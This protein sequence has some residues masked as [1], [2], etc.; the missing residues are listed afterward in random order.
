MGEDFPERGAL[1]IKVCGYRLDSLRTEDLTLSL[2]SF[3][4]PRVWATVRE[5]DGS[6]QRS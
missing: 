3:A 5:K 4:V 1:M 6:H 2:H